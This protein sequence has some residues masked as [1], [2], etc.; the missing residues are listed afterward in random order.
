MAELKREQAKLDNARNEFT[1]LRNETTLTFVH[2]QK[3]IMENNYFKTQLTQIEEENRSLLFEKVEI[4]S[5]I[6]K[7]KA[8]V[9]KLKSETEKSRF[10]VEKLIEDKAKSDELLLSKSELRSR[11]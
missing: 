6:E 4:K 11:A 5:E 3:C 10:G 8:E 2:A 1:S 9:E 7:L